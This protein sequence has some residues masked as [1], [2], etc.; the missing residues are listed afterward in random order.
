MQHKALLQY[1]QKL[2]VME[3]E[4]RRKS[5]KKL[6]KKMDAL[7]HV[8]KK[9]QPPVPIN[10]SYESVS[11]RIGI[12]YARMTRADHIPVQIRPRIE[13]YSEFTSLGEVHRVEVFH[14]FI[15]RMKVCANPTIEF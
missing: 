9:I 7:K 14:K 6:R 15:S 13:Q 4:E 11:W 2:Q 5:E 10:S 8:L 3:K 1:L 12:F